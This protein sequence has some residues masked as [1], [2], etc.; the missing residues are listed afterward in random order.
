GALAAWGVGRCARVV[1]RGRAAGDG[2]ATRVPPPD[3]TDQNGC[4]DA[5]T[6]AVGRPTRPV[7]RTPGEARW[8]SSTRVFIAKRLSTAAR[9]PAPPGVR[10][11]GFEPRLCRRNEVVGAARR[12]PSRPPSLPW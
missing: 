8:Q 6:S 10:A 11:P 1:E 5:G 9:A 2:V 4:T 3:D 12:G 7:S